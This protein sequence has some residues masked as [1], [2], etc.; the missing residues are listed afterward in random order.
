MRVRKRFGQHFL[1]SVWVRK[2]VQT[3]RP[4]PTDRFLE[5]GAGRGALTFPLAEAGARVLAVEIDRDLVAELAHAV[6]PTVQVIAGDFLTLDLQA[7]LTSLLHHLPHSP[8]PPHS[9]PSVRVVGNLPYSISSPILFRLLK[10]QQDLTPFTDAILMLQRE[11]AE[12]LVAPPGARSYGPLAIMTRFQAD[13]RRVLDLPPGAFRPQPRVHSAVVK[14]VFRPAPV[15]LTDPDRFD[16]MVRSL[17]SRRR[18]TV[19]NALKPF[20]AGIK[21]PVSA[22]EA[23][24]LADLDP[25]RRPETLQL[26][27]LARLAELFVSAAR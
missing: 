6:P 12:R 26:T 21:V 13:A 23:L 14:L 22:A 7:L 20:A 27:E 9:P 17:F 11:V 18:K 8:H 10:L 15:H 24:A 4:A 16:A 2:L 19:L 3:I 25:T 5:I 1:E